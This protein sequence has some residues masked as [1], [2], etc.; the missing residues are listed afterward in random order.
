M[1]ILT[2]NDQQGQYP[3]SHYAATATPLAQLPVATVQITCDVCVIGGGFTGF[4]PH[5]IWLK[6]AWMWCW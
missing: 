6:K 1:D 3:A 5:Y 4:Q 2:V